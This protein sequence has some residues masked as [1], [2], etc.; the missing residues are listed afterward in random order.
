M[1]VT[2]NAILFLFCLLMTYTGVNITEIN[3]IL[4]SFRRILRLHSLFIKATLNRRMCIRKAIR[5]I[6]MVFCSA[7]DFL[8]KI[9]S[10]VLSI[11]LSFL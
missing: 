11:Q 9:E 6:G 4:M 3:E 5:T 2:I 1:L 7:V 10:T 8:H